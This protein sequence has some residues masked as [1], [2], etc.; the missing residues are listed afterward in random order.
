MPNSD[1]LN[2]YRWSLT[3]KVAGGLLCFVI[4]LLIIF[5]IV[6]WCSR[7]PYTPPDTTGWQTGDIFFSAGNSWR[8]VIVKWFDSDNPDG[9]TH[10]GFVV[11]DNGKPYLVHM[12]TDEHQIVMES[13]GDYG[14]LNDVSSV[15]VRRLHEI[16]DTTTLR[17]NIMKLLAAHK[18]F[19]HKYDHRDSTAYYCTEFVVLELG[20][21]GSHAFDDLLQKEHIYPIDLAGSPAVSGIKIPEE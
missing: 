18:E 7:K 4:L 9:L 5:F 1:R 2:P 17:R 11:I 21:A 19:D 12:S 3:K 20:K 10:C 6:V 14:R 8:S 13:V 16:P 15:T